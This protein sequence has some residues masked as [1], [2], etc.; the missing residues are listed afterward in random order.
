MTKKN[1]KPTEKELEILQVLWDKG[2]VSVREVHEAMGGEGA[3]GY[4]T[5]LKFMQ[6]MHEKGLVT[7]QKNGKL[8]LYK[9]VPSLESTQQQI[10]DKMINTVFQG[11]AAQLVMSALGNKK[12]SKE[13]LHE[14]K[15]YLEKL[16]GG[17]S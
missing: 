8:H 6:I 3:N 17:E 1:I 7:R 4:T 11:S 9:A 5:I 14:I 15:K 13:E 2:A 12:S 16:E 10:L